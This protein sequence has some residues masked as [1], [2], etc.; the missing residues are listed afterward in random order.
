MVL[1]FLL[2]EWGMD[3]E[4][5]GGGEWYTVDTARYCLR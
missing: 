5:D 3:S 4:S 1:A 2:I